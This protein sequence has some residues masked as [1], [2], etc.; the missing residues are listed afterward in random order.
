MSTNAPV[1]RNAVMLDRVIGE[2][3]EGL[4]ANLD[5]LDVAF[6]RAQ[7][8]TKMMEDRKIIT[9]NVFC[10]GWNGHG[11]YDYMEVSPDSKI[12]NFSFFDIEDPQTITPGPWARE[13]KVPFGLVFWF[14]LTRI[15]NEENNRNI[16]QLKAQALR[17]LNGRAGW[18]LNGGRITINRIYD[19]AENIYRGYNIS[20]ID[21]QFLMHPFG[22]FRLE[23]VL[24]FEEVCFT[25]VRPTPTA[26]TL[27]IGDNDLGEDFIN[28]KIS[29]IVGNSAVVGGVLMNNITDSIWSQSAN[30][31]DAGSIMPGTWE[32][33]GEAEW[34]YDRTDANHICT[35]EIWIK[36]GQVFY[37]HTPGI[38]AGHITIMA[39]GDN[40]RRVQYLFPDNLV[41]FSNS[42]FNVMVV[43]IDKEYE[44]K[45]G[46]ICLNISN[47]ALN[48]KYFDY[49]LDR[50]ILSTSQI[51]GR[52]PAGVIGR[53]FRDGLKSC[54]NVFDEISG[55]EAIQRVNI[56]AYQAGDEEN[57]SVLTDGT[58]TNYP[59]EIP[60][61]WEIFSIPSTFRVALGGSLYRTPSSES[62]N[63]ETIVE[64]YDN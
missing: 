64:Y 53:P 58:I 24:E 52:N 36:P 57:P 18:Y 45:I 21:N 8:L 16:E 26:K 43:I 35:P 7:R 63:T 3:Q 6:G 12:G 11:D 27:R 46:Q 37:L 38:P 51:Q 59:L 44:D 23:G 4:I 15:Y 41:D 61:V 9:P 1:I 2:I 29:R 30:Y 40:S 10:G 54:G 14:D 56:R 17:V 47:P 50:L 22:G 34:T 20:E 60:V 55:S 28:G 31:F 19:R 39:K 13:I 48:G 49:W 25:D 5:W 32:W 62:N 33:G 42:N